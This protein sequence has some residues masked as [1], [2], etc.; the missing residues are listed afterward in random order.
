MYGWTLS[1][2]GQ[3]PWG[4]GSTQKRPSSSH[5]GSGAQQ[6]FPLFGPQE[7]WT[8]VVPSGQRGEMQK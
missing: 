2:G 8:G 6:T 5:E 3:L 1:P 7:A 4:L